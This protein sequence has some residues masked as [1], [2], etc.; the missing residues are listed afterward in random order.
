MSPNNMPP[1]LQQIDK[2]LTEILAEIRQLRTDMKSASASDIQNLQ[3]D[4]QV[5]QARKE[6]AEAAQAVQESLKRLDSDT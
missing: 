5:A 2:E 4:P 3:Q 1:D 6:L